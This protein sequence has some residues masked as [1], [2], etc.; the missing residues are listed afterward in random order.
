M[1]IL[2]EAINEVEPNAELRV[3]GVL[4]P[5]TLEALSGLDEWFMSQWLVRKRVDFM[6]DIVQRR[7][8][9]IKFLGGWVTRAMAF[10]TE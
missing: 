6:V 7:P 5:N 9:Q 4:G 8:E 2:Q 10:L 3:D 1:R